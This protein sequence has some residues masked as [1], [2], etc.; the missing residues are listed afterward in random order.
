MYLKRLSQFYHHPLRLGPAPHATP[1]SILERQ[2]PKPL[3]K[4]PVFPG[5]SD[6]AAFAATPPFTKTVH[7]IAKTPYFHA[8]KMLNGV[9]HHPWYEYDRD[10]P[11]VDVALATSAAPT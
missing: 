4:L 1:L 2:V 3:P 8:K 7:R 11:A 5:F 6:V 10:L 9:A